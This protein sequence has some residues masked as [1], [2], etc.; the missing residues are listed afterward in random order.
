[1]CAMRVFDPTMKQA[2]LWHVRIYAYYEVIFTLMD[3]RQRFFSLSAAFYSIDWDPYCAS[4]A[5]RAFKIPGYKKSLVSMSPFQLRS[6]NENLMPRHH[7][8]S[9]FAN[10][11][12]QDVLKSHSRP[13]HIRVQHCLSLL[14]RQSFRARACCRHFNPLAR[15][16]RT[17]D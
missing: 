14:W 12:N 16:C 15:L 13:F 4:M 8:I 9:S 7:H 2:S 11:N 3:L 5:K 10:R 6:G 1:M 17:F